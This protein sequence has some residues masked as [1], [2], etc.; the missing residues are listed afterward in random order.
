MDSVGE[1]EGGKIWENGINKCFLKKFLW[2]SKE[3]DS[4]R[5]N[6]G[7]H[8]LLRLQKKKARLSEGG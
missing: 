7:E 2:E 4:K 6:S 1:G 5:P 8:E 3:E